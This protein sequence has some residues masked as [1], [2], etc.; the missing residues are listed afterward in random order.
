MSGVC[1]LR[2]LN[3]VPHLF[4]LYGASLMLSAFC[5]VLL[6]QHRRLRERLR[7]MERPPDSPGNDRAGMAPNGPL[8]DKGGRSYETQFLANISHEL[9]TPLNSMLILSKLLRKNQQGRLTAVEL[10]WVD[11][12]CSCG[13]DLL[14]LIEDILDFS[15]MEAGKLK[16]DLQDVPLRA[17]GEQLQALFQCQA[18]EKE[19]EF[20]VEFDSSIPETVH[21]DPDR[22]Q[23][24]LRNLVANAIKFTETGWVRVI[25]RLV[26]DLADD[27]SGRLT[28]DHGPALAISVLDTGIGIAKANKERVFEAFR[29]ED[30]GRARRFGGTGLGLTISKT[31][32]DLLGGTIRL[33]TE[34]GVGSTFTLYL[35]L[36]TREPA[37]SA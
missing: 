34:K 17:V 20:S 3:R 10:K 9:R 23:Q 22:L 27:D 21:T 33:D 14:K 16:L 37:N 2:P 8:E 5:V 18:A 26:D 35:P 1:S 31:L 36:G 6:W 11:T 4:G 24:V 29:Q 7:H 15:R 13:R 28:A 30:A 19:L 32:A 25:F 12:I